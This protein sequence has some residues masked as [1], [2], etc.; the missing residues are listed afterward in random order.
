M[1]SCASAFMMFFRKKKWGGKTWG[2]HCER[3]NMF[4]VIIKIWMCDS[5]LTA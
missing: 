3:K 4:Q 2:E 5:D 1:F